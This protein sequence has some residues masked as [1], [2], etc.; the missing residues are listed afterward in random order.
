MG[1]FLI[2]LNISWRIFR[3]ALL[4][5]VC[6]AAHVTAAL[7]APRG[8]S[9]H[10]CQVHVVLFT[11]ISGGEMTCYAHVRFTYRGIVLPHD[12]H[13]PFP[14]LISLTAVPLTCPSTPLAIT[15]SQRP[16]PLHPFTFTQSPHNHDPQPNQT[17]ANAY[18]FFRSINFVSSRVPAPSP[19]RFLPGLHPHRAMTFNTPILIHACLQNNADP[20][21][22]PRPE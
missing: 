18:L 3:F 22:A 21:F 5:V 16:S 14:T 19:P 2:L 8:L 9:L 13:L 11:I 15:T 20:L 7:K 4:A 1:R 6:R 17:N 10:T 12:D